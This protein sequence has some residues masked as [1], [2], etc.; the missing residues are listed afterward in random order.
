MKPSV[1]LGEIKRKTRYMN[2][3]DGLMDIVLGVHLVLTYY[4]I[5]YRLLLNIP[6]IVI[7]P[8]IVEAIRKRT[9][10]PRIGYARVANRGATALRILLV[11]VA[12]IVL[13]FAVTALIF[14]LLGLP[15]Q[16]NW[17][18]VLKLAAVLLIPVIFGLLAHEHRVYRWFVYGVLIGLGGLFVRAIAPNSLQFYFAILGGVVSVIGIAIFLD[19]LN[20]HPRQPE[21]GSDGA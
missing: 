14:L 12:G 2:F 16:N 9:T 6:W 11:C 8:L 15:V 4:V 21:E 20:K 5:E 1:D 3:Q 10:Y 7:G 13:L 18:H 17:H 19:F